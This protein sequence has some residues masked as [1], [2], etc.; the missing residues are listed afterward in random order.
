VLT[1]VIC[2]NG[3]L[4]KGRR[5][6]TC[7][8]ATCVDPLSERP[9]S[10]S[11]KLIPSHCTTMPVNI[12]AHVFE[13]GIDSIPYVWTILKVAPFIAVLYLLKWYSNGAVNTSERNMHSKVVIVTVC[14]LSYSM[15]AYLIHISGRNSRHRR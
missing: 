10:A 14:G 8:D 1:T 7:Y 5:A 15:R 13:Q 9:R 6:I 11:P 2:E 3:E 12:L 4:R